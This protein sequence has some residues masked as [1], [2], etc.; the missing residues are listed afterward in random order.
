MEYVKQNLKIVY[1]AHVHL[2]TMTRTFVKFQNN[3]PKL[4]EELRT[5]VTH[6]VFTLFALRTKKATIN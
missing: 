1:K 3:Q 6:Y 2:K 4:L 5:Q